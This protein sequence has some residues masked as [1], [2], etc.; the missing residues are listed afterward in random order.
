MRLITQ[1][2]N[3]CRARLK[4]STFR[5]GWADRIQFEPCILTTALHAVLTLPAAPSVPAKAHTQVDCLFVES[6]FSHQTILNCAIDDWPPKTQKQNYTGFTA[7]HTKR[8]SKKIIF[9]G[10]FLQTFLKKMETDVDQ[11][12]TWS[13]VSQITTNPVFKRR[14]TISSQKW[15]G[16]IISSLI[17]LQMTNGHLNV[18]WNIIWTDH[19]SFN[20]KFNKRRN[21]LSA[22][23]CCTD[24][25][26]F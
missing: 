23:A 13:A 19:R 10:F 18:V 2:L 8:V 3:Q 16:I 15:S 22:K 12:R 6:A 14:K 9:P 1:S 7:E 11:T 21:N 4:T 17:S 25:D 5:A 20:T 26:R 24:T